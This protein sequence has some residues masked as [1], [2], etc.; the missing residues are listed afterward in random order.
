MPNIHDLKESRFVTQQDVGKGILV[1]IRGYEEMDVAK[2]GC[3]PEMRWALWFDELEKPMT[4]N[5]TKGQLIADIC[6][7]QKGLSVEESEQFEN[8]IGLVV[9]I[10]RDPNYIFAGRQTGRILVRAPK[11]G[12][13]KPSIRVHPS[14]PPPRVE[15]PDD[16]VP[17]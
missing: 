3:E 13:V 9:V 14:V 4:L 17:F 6:Q 1:T 10:Y 2:P 12:F 8:W 5:T 15:E 11:E 7:Q 16:G